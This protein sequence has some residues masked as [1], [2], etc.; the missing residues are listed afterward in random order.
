MWSLARICKTP[1]VLTLNLSAYG[2]P[3]A[4]CRRAADDDCR[5]TA[6]S[7][8]ALSRQRARACAPVARGRNAGR[9]SARRA[10]TPAYQQVYA[11]PDA[12]A[13][14]CDRGRA[15]TAATDLLSACGVDVLS[16]RVS[17]TGPD[18][19][20]VVSD[21]YADKH[22]ASRQLSRRRFG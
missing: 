10:G 7:S 2:W 22:S 4:P 18:L 15:S 8:R 11:R 19:D 6:A 21:A 14:P 12:G 20:R 13:E 9:Q 16:W 3:S 5:G 17:R 1:P